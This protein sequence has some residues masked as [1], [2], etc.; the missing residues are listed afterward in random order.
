MSLSYV[1]NL[2]EKVTYFAL[3]KVNIMCTIS[4]KN[5]VAYRKLEDG[6]YFQRRKMY[7]IKF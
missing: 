5:L 2:N 3:N 6:L 7:S 1:F 4:L